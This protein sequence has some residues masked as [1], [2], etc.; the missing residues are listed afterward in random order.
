MVLRYGS[1][2]LYRRS[3]LSLGISAR[4]IIFTRA[5]KRGVTYTHGENATTTR[6]TTR[7]GAGG[8]IYYHYSLV[9]ENI[10][11]YVM[12]FRIDIYI[13]KGAT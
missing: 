8:R 7:E 6:T 2:V 3:M 5:A 11:K 9:K 10:I 13:L 12:V 4:L 1:M